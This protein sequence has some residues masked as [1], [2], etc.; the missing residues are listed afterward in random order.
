MFQCSGR[1]SGNE[2]NV[3]HSQEFCVGFLK[4]RVKTKAVLK[5]TQRPVVGYLF[6]DYDFETRLF[7]ELHVYMCADSIVIHEAISRQSPPLIFA[8]LQEVDGRY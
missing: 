6:V 7:E 2:C 4:A 1:N 3:A 8:K 5:R